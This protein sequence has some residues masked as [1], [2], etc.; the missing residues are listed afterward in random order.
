M[1]KGKSNHSLRLQFVDGSTYTVDF[2]PLLAESKS[3]KLLK[4]PDVFAQATLMEGEGWA[5]M[6]PEQDIQIGADSLWLD[7]QAQ[8]APD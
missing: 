2:A 1:L 7:A 3:L 4:D 8:N 6:W 5:L